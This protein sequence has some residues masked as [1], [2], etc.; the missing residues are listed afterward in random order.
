MRAT[1]LSLQLQWIALELK[2]DVVEALRNQPRKRRSAPNTLDGQLGR[3]G[4]LV[5]EAATGMRA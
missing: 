5:A 1:G 2:R 4:V 3:N